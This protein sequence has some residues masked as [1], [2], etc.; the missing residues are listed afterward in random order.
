MRFDFETGR[1]L[2]QSRHGSATALVANPWLLP[3]EF[4]VDQAGVVRLAY[5][6]QD[7][8]DWPG[9]ELLTAAIKEAARNE[10]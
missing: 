1:E 5:R 2:Q 3:G 9:K 10:G 7:C 4:V 6:Y 8:Q